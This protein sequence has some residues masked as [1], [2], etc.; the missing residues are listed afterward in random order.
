ME[1]TDTGFS[2]RVNISSCVHGE[3]IVKGK[4]IPNKYD[5]CIATFTDFQSNWAISNSLY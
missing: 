3:T 1:K 5:G 2:V 4:N